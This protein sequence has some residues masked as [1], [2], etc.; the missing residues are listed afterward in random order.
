VKFTFKFSVLLLTGPPGIGKSTIIQQVAARLGSRAGGFYT[1]EVRQ[2]GR[3]TG[4]EIVT[5]N[6][7]TTPLAMTSPHPAFTAEAPFG[8]YRINLAGLDD[9]AIPTLRAALDQGQ[10]IIIDEIGPM[11]LL[12]EPFCRMVLDLLDSQAP[13][14]GTIVQRPHPFADRVKAHPRVRL[15]PVTAANRE[16]LV[17]EIYAEISGGGVEL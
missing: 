5:L 10:V 13:V 3:R 9:L 7:Q 14:V 8:R 15:K 2:A 11:E 17:D 4:F 16:G 1:R 12:S 6:G